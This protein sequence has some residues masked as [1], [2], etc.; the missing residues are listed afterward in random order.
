M[1]YKLYKIIGTDIGS[2]PEEYEIPSYIILS[3]GFI[4]PIFKR[5]YYIKDHTINS[6][7]TSGICL[8]DNDSDKVLIELYNIER[9]SCVPVFRVRELYESSKSQIQDFILTEL[10]VLEELSN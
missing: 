6:N 4:S 5:K 9:F 1:T 2:T 7:R 3:V 8:I 10:A